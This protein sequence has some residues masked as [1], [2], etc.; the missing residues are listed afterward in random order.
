MVVV[1]IMF[2]NTIYRHMS[3][4]FINIRYT[5]QFLIYQQKHIIANTCYGLIRKYDLSKSLRN[6]SLSNKYLHNDI[7]KKC[8][9]S[10]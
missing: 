5:S 2:L 3:G 6:K 7:Q 1:P 10:S 4:K 8:V 9:H